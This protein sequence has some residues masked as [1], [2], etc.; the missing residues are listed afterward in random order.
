MA[1]NS[2]TKA[3]NKYAAKNYDNLRIIV[4][5]GGKEVIKKAAEQ[6]GTRSIN[7]YVTRAVNEKLI[8]DGFEPMQ[9]QENK[10]GKQWVTKKES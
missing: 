4:P 7:G 1:G 2:S 9:K 3:K 5:K 10:E 6:S 8:K